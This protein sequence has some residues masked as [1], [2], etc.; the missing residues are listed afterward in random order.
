M[1]ND[2]DFKERAIK[3]IDIYG[4]DELLNKANLTEEEVIA[5]L[6][7]EGYLDPEL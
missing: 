3:L 4:F 2:Y 7:E 6:I 5:L 1:F